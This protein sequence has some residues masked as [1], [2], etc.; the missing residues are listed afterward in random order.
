MVFRQASAIRIKGN[1]R[2]GTLIWYALF[3]GLTQLDEQGQP[4]PGA[5]A[6]MGAGRADALAIRVATRR[7]LRGRHAVRC[8]AAAA[9]IEWLVSKPAGAR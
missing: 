2:P 4:A 1:G 7:A 3:D 9:V 6:V 5:R 8:R